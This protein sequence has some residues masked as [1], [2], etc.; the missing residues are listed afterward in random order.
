MPNSVP[1][2]LEIDLLIR[3]LTSCTALTHSRLPASSY[4][5]YVG[6]ISGYLVK[7]QAFDSLEPF[8]VFSVLS[9]LHNRSTLN[10]D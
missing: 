8:Y 10:Q 9:A 3:S 1:E 2:L 4:F 6:K 7:E 5:A